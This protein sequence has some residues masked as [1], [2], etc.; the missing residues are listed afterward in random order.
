MPGHCHHIALF[1]NNPKRLVRFYADKLGFVKEKESFASKEILKPIFGFNKDCGLIKLNRDGM[2]IEIIYLKDGRFGPRKDA[3]IGYTHWAYGV[4]D[5]EGF[6][7]ALAK[8][9]VSVIRVD[10]AGH[11]VFFIKDPDGNRIELQ[12]C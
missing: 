7:K 3:N 9:G 2:W 1:T 10:R 11:P 8:K 6:A 12:E 4:G 5:K